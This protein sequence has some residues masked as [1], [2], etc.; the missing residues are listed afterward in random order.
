MTT[1]IKGTEVSIFC[2]LDGHGGEFAAV[3]A[4][5]HLMEKLTKKIVE[6][7]DVS[8]GKITPLP[9]RRNSLITITDQSEVAE[10]DDGTKSGGA[11]QSPTRS[12][13]QRRKL[14]KT[15]STDNDCNPAQSNCN[16][17]QDTFLSK[18]G[19]IR[20]TKESFMKKEK[21]IKP[22]EYEASYYVDRTDKINFGKMITDLVLLTDYDLVEKAKKQ[23]QFCFVH[24]AVT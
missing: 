15:L 7:V 23:V 17:E 11:H 3:Y 14:K 2:I 9:H 16:Q 13:S 19:S 4:K 5:E 20:L 8:T 6:A 10:K 21:I 22:N 1:N 24:I 18:L 12:E